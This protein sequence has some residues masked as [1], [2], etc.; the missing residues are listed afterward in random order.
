MHPARKERVLKELQDATPLELT[1]K[2]KIEVG[3]GIITNTL[4]LRDMPTLVFESEGKKTI[5]CL[6]LNHVGVGETEEE[7][8]FQFGEDVS[9]MLAEVFAESNFFKHLL[10][11]FN[12]QANKIYWSEHKKLTR[13]HSKKA[14]F[15]KDVKRQIKNVELETVIPEKDNSLN[16]SKK[17]ESA[18]QETAANI[19]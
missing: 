14:E 3:K 15:K 4:T 13:K 1:V 2:F 9:E 6:P 11:L 19:H 5:K 10:E 17:L 8:F 7:A 18:Y 16:Y 12:G